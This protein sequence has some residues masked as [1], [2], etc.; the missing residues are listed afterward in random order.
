MLWSFLFSFRGRINRAKYWLGTLIFPASIIILAIIYWV[1][2]NFAGSE[3]TNASRVNAIAPQGGVPELI[4]LILVIGIS[5]CLWW[6][7]IAVAVKR[8]HDR[9]KSGWW[10]IVFYVLPNILSGGIRGYQSVGSG[11]ALALILT[12][13][14]LAIGV[15]AFVE[16]GCLRGTPGANRFGPDPLE[17]VRHLKEVFS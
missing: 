11:S 9:D 8:L 6:I 15:W 13:A 1:A 4:V 5:L 2:T 14:C 10:L 17:S 16:L 12:L 7:G 3:I